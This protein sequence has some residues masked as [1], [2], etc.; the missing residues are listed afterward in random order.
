M[1]S[2]T[3]E[4]AAPAPSADQ[5][6]SR[7]LRISPG[8]LLEVN[9]YGVDELKREVRVS[10]GGEISLPLVGTV[11]VAG[12][13]SEEAERA[14]AA[15]LQE[16]LFVKNPQVSV[17]VKEYATQGASVMGEVTKPGIYPVYGVRRLFDLLSAAGGTTNKA[18]R[19]ITIT[20]RT[21]PGHSISVSLTDDPARSLESNV[22]IFPGDTIIVSRAGIVYVVGDV[23]KPGGFVME[24]NERLSILQAIALAQGTNRTAA[25][26]AAKLIRRGPTGP[27]E[28]PIPLNKILSAKA[29]DEYLQP[30]DIVFVPNSATKTATRRG[31]EAVLQTVTGV[32]IYS[33]AH[34]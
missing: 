17:F 34:Y 9:V 3:T 29:P 1:S 28:Y 8:D 30:E 4:P 18:G 6:P 14:V 20:R 26:S 12:L 32:I 2:A 21:D 19:L 33:S 10:S 31:L 23:G 25:L 11:K 22:D 15:K 16:G 13:A 7:A 27:Q 24:N 5:A